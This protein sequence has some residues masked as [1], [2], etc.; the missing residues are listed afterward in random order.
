MEN[1]YD[2]VYNQQGEVGVRFI[3]QVVRYRFSNFES[4]IREHGKFYYTSLE[5]FGYLILM[6][7]HDK[8][9]KVMLF[10]LIF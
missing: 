8:I 7:L 6:L 3:K 9:D 4:N 5:I 2:L 10:Y 1:P